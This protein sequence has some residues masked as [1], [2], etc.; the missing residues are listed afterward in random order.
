MVSKPSTSV[1]DT[2]NALGRER[3]PTGPVK[4]GESPGK[5]F[6]EERNDPESEPGASDGQPQHHPASI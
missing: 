6:N 3:R 1:P 2:P 5:R 4:P